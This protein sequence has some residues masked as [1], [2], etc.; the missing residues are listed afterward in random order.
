MAKSKD[1]K[2]FLES[3]LNAIF[4]ATVSDILE[5]VDQ[6]LSEY[7]GKLQRIETENEDLRQRL[8]DQDNKDSVVKDPGSNQYAVHLPDLSRKTC[9]SHSAVGQSQKPI[10]TQGDERRSSRRQQKDKMLQSRGSVSFTDTAAQQEPECLKN[11]PDTAVSTLIFKNIKTEPDMEDDYAI[12]LSKPPSPLNLASKQM[13]TESAEVNYIIPEEHDEHLQSP[14]DTDVDSRDSDSDVKVTIVSDSHMAMEMGD[15]CDHFVES[16]EGCVTMCDEGPL[17]NYC[18]KRFGRADLLKSHKRTHT[19]ER[20]FSCDLCGKNYG[21]PG[22]LRIHKRCSYGRETV[23]A[24]HTPQLHLR[25]LIQGR[26]L[27]SCCLTVGRSF[28]RSGHLKRHEQVHTKR[29]ASTL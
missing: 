20:P 15:E 4:K 14:L 24:A 22:Q 10:K 23:L 12:D 6:T 8:H 26:K 27:F 13:K 11:I 3:S 25:K 2:V 17:R 1:L 29:E 16:E 18:G 7:K 9:S 19:G 5:S 28:G 21:H